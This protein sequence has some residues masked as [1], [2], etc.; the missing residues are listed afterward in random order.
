MK[1]INLKV[2]DSI[3]VDGYVTLDNDG[4]LG[5]GGYLYDAMGQKVPVIGLAKMTS[6]PMIPSKER[7]TAAKARLYCS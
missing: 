4:K 7:Y 1:K 3:I 6:M 5:L 2:G